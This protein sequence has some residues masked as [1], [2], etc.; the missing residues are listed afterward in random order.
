MGNPKRRKKLIAFRLSPWT[1]ET[2]Q[3]ICRKDESN[4]RGLIESL[5]DD[6]LM[7]C[8][9]NWYAPEV[10]KRASGNHEILC[11]MFLRYCQAFPKDGSGTP[12]GWKVY[13]DDETKKVVFI[14]KP[15]DM[16]NYPVE[17][18]TRAMSLMVEKNRKKR[19]KKS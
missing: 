14:Y 6:F 13:R 2:L 7:E 5:M 12:P 9:E 1:I 10:L 4:M 18:F 19:G 17:G 3:E 8:L 11:E 16:V 15:D